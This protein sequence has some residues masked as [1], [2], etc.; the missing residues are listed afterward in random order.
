[1]L[2]ANSVFSLLSEEEL[3]PFPTQAEFTFTF[4]SIYSRTK[5]AYPLEFLG[6]RVTHI[7]PFTVRNAL[8]PSCQWMSAVTAVKWINMKEEEKM[9]DKLSTG[10]ES[11]DTFVRLQGTMPHNTTN[12]SRP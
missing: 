8:N 7:V 2:N 12:S 11:R 9:C 10:F 1:V 4:R 3:Q 5:H 6:L